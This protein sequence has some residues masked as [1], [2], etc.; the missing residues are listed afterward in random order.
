MTTRHCK[1]YPQTFLSADICQNLKQ[2]TK[3]LCGTACGMKNVVI[4][5]SFYSGTEWQKTL[6]IFT[7]LHIKQVFYFWPLLTTR[8]TDYHPNYMMKIR[9]KMT[10]AKLEVSIIGAR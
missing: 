1:Y 6:L 7:Q 10:L 9:P 3:W 5:S 2:V 4:V 8:G